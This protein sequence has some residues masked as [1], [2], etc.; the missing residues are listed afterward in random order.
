MSSI[1]KTA[2]IAKGAVLGEGVEI[3][4]YCVIGEN[5][6]IGAGTR[7][8]S[9]VVIDGITKIGKECTVY[10]FASIGT[11]TQ[12]LKY[13][14][15][16]TYVTIG[17]RTTLREYVT[18]N[19]ATNDGETTSVGSDCHILAYSHIAHACQVGNGIIMS[20]SV[21]LAG[22]VVVEDG[23]TF[24]GLTGVH[25]FVRI[26]KMCMVG[27]MSKL[28]KD[29]PPYITADGYPAVARGLN[30][31]GMSRK[32]VSE[33]AQRLIKQAYRILYRQNLTT[34]DALA[35]IEAEIKGCSEVD[36]FVRFVRGSE[37]G[38]V[39]QTAEG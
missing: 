23:V 26:G 5:V 21:N 17:D 1:D 37:R 22:H 15:G 25:Q 7:L 29:C 39:R 18:V 19:S 8:I 2:V 38:F 12:D 35:K 33:E 4:P 28:L 11:R 27:G 10:P 20:N 13:K 9:H 3:G 32:G 6:E 31:V 16:K 30:S 24:G 36:E 14:G 34:Q